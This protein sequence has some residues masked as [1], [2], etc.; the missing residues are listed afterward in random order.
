MYEIDLK[1]KGMMCGGCE[2]RVKLDEIKKGDIVVCGA[3][4]KI[5]DIVSGYFVP[6]VIIIAFL[7]FAFNL[8]IGTSFLQSL[9]TFVTILVVACPCS[10]G[11]AV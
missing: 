7:A 8:I 11:L 3:G 9:T 10:L 4:E 2:N 1:V 5:A 6:S